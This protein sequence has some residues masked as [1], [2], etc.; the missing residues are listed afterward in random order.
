MRVTKYGIAR[1]ESIKEAFMTFSPVH[2]WREKCSISHL[3]TYL[4]PKLPST[5][6]GIPAMSS[7]IYLMAS[8]LFLPL[9]SA[10]KI[11]QIKPRGIAIARVNPVTL[12]VPA[13]R[14]RI[15][16]SASS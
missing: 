16:N 15:P 9:N 2:T 8:W 3:E 11:E 7:K 5:T 13:S 6:D 12:R 10:R 4:S 1:T 14:A